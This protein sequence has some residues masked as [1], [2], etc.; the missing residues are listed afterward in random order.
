MKYL[1]YHHD[2]KLACQTFIGLR[3]HWFGRYAGV[4][5]WKVERSRLAGDMIS[6]FFVERNNC[7]AVVNGRRWTLK[8]GDLLVTLG[9]DE[10]EFGHDPARPHVS[11]SVSL[12][13]EQGGVANALLCR[14]FQRRYTWRKPDEY[15]AEFEKVLAALASASPSR[16]LEIAGALLQWLAYVLAYLRPPLDRAFVEERSVVDKILLAETWANARLRQVIT[17][18]EWARAVGL[19]AV[20]FG[21]VFKRETGLRPMAW[22]NQRRLQMACQHLASTS[23][24]VTEIA[25]ACGFA[26]PFYF[27]RQF[28]RH[29][30]LSPLRYRRTSFER[31]PERSAKQIPAR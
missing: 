21:R 2:W 17:L 25:E 1:P 3:V 13:L 7:W 8:R 23:K 10:F 6:F 18:A 28:R 31:K 12:A 24:T 15:I 5:D 11:L 29:H 14:K 27:S 20:Y 16:D 9:G 19:N 22:L 4:P 26:S 30:G